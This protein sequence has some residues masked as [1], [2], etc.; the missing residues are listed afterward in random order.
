MNTWNKVRRGLLGVVLAGLML[1]TA[2]LPSAEAVE[3]EGAPKIAFIY[4]ATARDGGW[5]EAL[6]NARTAVEADLGVKIAVVESIKE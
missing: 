6:D 2:P 1:T 4:A 3:I 5:N